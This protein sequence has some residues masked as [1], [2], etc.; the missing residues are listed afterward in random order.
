MKDQPA[1][2][3]V[4]SPIHF[5]P[6]HIF[7]IL[8]ASNDEHLKVCSP[9]RFVVAVGV[10]CFAGQPAAVDFESGAVAAAD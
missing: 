1:F 5:C 3:H 4:Q 8:C 6:A 9:A 2:Q 7:A 10:S